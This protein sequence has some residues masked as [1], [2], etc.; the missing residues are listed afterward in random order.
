MKCPA[1]HIVVEVTDIGIVGL[2]V[3][4]LG[5]ITLGKNL[6]KRSLAAADIT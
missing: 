4:G 1:T 5:T 6:G 2:L 3:I